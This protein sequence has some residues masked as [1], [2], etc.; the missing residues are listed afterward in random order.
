[1]IFL[2]PLT[3]PC[4]RGKGPRVGWLLVS[5]F[6]LFGYGPFLWVG[7]VKVNNIFCNLFGYKGMSLTG[8]G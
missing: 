2:F 6:Y 8:D 7:W 4:K 5:H 3:G 1:M